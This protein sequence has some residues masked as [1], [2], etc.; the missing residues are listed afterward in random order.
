MGLDEG[1][2]LLLTTTAWASMKA[3][4]KDGGLTVT[5]SVMQ[6]VVCAAWA[7]G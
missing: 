6:I 3:G 7:C 2:R 1:G 5:I 4:G